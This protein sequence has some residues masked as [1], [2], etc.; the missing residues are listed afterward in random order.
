[1]REAERE[2]PGALGGHRRALDRV[3]ADLV[4][5]QACFARN[6]FPRELDVFRWQYFDGPAEPLFVD[7]LDTGSKLGAIYAT[8]AVPVI[9]R[10]RRALAVQ[11]LD[12][13][14]DEDFR[15]RG[16]FVDLAK[17]VYA[18]AAAAG[19]EFVYGFPNGQS[20]HGF[21]RRLGWRA[22]DPVPFLVRPLRT[23][24]AAR[25][26]HA[27]GRWLPDL[28][29]PVGPAWLG[30][31]QRLG[32][33]ARFT[34]EHTEVWREFA[35]S[36]GVAVDRDAAYLNWRL[37]DKPGERYRRAEVR[38]G[39]RVVAF[40]A[41]CVKDKHG[42]RVGYLM[43]LVHRRGH[44][45]TARRLLRH[46]LREMAAERADL[47]LAWSLPHSPSHAAMRAAG[48]LPLPARL[49]PIELHFGSCSFVPDGAAEQRNEWYLSYCDSDTV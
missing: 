49:R 9:V 13:L 4:A 16:L 48:F 30:A 2:D 25:R 35:A 24:Y 44:A 46:A 20:A 43:E 39:G 3:D 37:V 5:F 15:G 21:F 23:G 6:G 47:A 32:D 26:A 42:G 10:G 33:L 14:T 1:M 8:F 7:V 28:P 45:R 41:W 22:L 27:L 31:A 18:R 11:S 29:V 40:A 38:E 17:R 12:T 19:V 34:D 36:I